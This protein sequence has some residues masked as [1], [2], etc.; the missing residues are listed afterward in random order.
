MSN[1]AVTYTVAACSATFALAAFIAFIVIPAWTSYS[2][3]W[4]RIAATFL[5]L[6]VLAA[7]LVLGVAA[8]AAVAYYW[9]QLAA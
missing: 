2:K 3:A 1:Q 8:G 9:D 4:E 6:Y 5:S 7:L